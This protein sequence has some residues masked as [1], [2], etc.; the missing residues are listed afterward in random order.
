M[1]FL[2]YLYV[3]FVLI[4]LVFS[5]CSSDEA[6]AD[7]E[8]MTNVPFTRDV[9]IDTCLVIINE[10]TDFC[11]WKKVFETMDGLRS[12]YG[13]EVVELFQGS[14][15]TNLTVSLNN[16]SSLEGADEFINSDKLN[17]SMNNVSFEDATKLHFLDQQLEY[18]L[19]TNDT[20]TMYMTFKTLSYKR[21]EKAFLDDYRE[22][23]NRDFE[24]VRV[25][26]GVDE[27][28]HVHMIFKVNDPEY[29]EKSE[30]NNA[31]KM[32]MLAAGVVSYPVTYN[33]RDVKI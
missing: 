18:T 11:D 30:Q 9:S 17:S 1:R 3:Y 5:S 28:N 24:V 7:N 16:I 26:R 14:Q 2:P 13:I 27:P 31:F 20:L 4:A 6:S 29:I 25:F 10:L 21:W 23:P 8:D 19:E 15:D 33:L 12:T 22:D 32:K